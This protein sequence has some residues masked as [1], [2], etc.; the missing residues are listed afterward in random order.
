MPPAG[1]YRTSMAWQARYGPLGPVVSAAAFSPGQ[2]LAAPD[3]EPVRLWDLSQLK[4]GKI[5]LEQAWQQAEAWGAAIIAKAPA[6]VHAAINAA[7]VDVKQ[8]ASDAV[9]AADTLAG[10]IIDGAAQAAGSA[11]AAAASAYLGPVGGAVTPAALDA[12]DR[13]RDG[14]KAELDTL[15]LQLKSQLAASP[16]PGAAPAA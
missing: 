8:A 11:F 13:I 4:N 14:V 5:T 1:G 12:I 15:A 9:G 16:S 10:P 7:V 2:P 6:S 3:P